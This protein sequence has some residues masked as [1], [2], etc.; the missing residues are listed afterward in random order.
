MNRYLFYLG[1]ALAFVQPLHAE[2]VSAA[3]WVHVMASNLPP[4][5]CE[6]G[7]YFGSCFT[8][9]NDTCVTH[10]RGLIRSCS[11]QGRWPSHIQTDDPK[12]ALRLGTCFGEKFEKQN[13]GAKKSDRRCEQPEAWL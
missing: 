11:K 8:L 2:R 6:P 10:I 7:S 1:M 4:I 12:M 5:L 3:K 9:S 13:M